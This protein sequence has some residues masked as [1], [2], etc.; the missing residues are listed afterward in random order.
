ML[1]VNLIEARKHFSDKMAAS[2]IS[3][4]SGKY[5]EDLTDVTSSHRLR[6][7]QS[8]PKRRHSIQVVSGF[9]FLSRQPSFKDGNVTP[10]EG[11]SA[12][13]NNNGNGA[14]GTT[15]NRGR[16]QSISESLQLVTK[17]MSR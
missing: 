10:A 12:T 2:G 8:K 16:R 15:H 5:S 3:P 13:A 7:L 9:P 17:S 6:L 1:A 4:G 11:N 14:D